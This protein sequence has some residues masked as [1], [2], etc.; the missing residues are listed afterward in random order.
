MSHV[1]L[2]ALAIFF[3]CSTC[4][5]FVGFHAGALHLS[6]QAVVLVLSGRIQMYYQFNI[7]PVKLCLFNLVG[8]RN[9]QHDAVSGTCYASGGFWCIKNRTL[10]FQCSRQRNLAFLEVWHVFPPTAVSAILDSRPNNLGRSQP[11]NDTA[12]YLKFI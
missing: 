3:Q 5:F 11:N 9:L 2:C 8:F 12:R 1:Y 7:F 4:S 10:M 6:L